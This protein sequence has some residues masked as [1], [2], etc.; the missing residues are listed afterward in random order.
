MARLLIADIDKNFGFILKQELEDEGY[1]V[2]LSLQGGAMPD[3]AGSREYDIVLLDMLMPCLD[4]FNRIKRIKKNNPAA[5]IV[6][7]SDSAAQEE[8]ASL[9]TA[10]A[11]ACFAR[12][13][14]KKMKIYLRR[15]LGNGC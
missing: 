7:F 1:A 6:I 8:T 10:G 5:H 9:L 4:H 13:E 2:D 15:R 14:I 3:S 12:H 11:E